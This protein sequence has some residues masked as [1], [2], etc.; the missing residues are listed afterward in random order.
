M[1]T[2]IPSSG[3]ELP[4]KG[5]CA[6]PVLLFAQ[7]KCEWTQQGLPDLYGGHRERPRGG[8]RT[9]ERRCATIL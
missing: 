9:P 1:P 3:A 7:A 6:W 5:L 2:S 8:C 4:W